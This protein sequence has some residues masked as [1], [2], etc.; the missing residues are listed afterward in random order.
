MRMVF[1]WTV[2]ILNQV[3]DTKFNHTLMLDY[4]MQDLDLGG[5]RIVEL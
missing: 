1:L 4:S 3:M 5:R 2:K